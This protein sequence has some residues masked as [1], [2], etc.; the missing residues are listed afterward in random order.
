MLFRHNNLIRRARIIQEIR[1]FFVSQGF[2]EVETPLRIPANAPEEYIDPIC[3]ANWF[4]QTSPEI[5]MKR[6]LCQ[7]HEK[8]FQISHCWRRGERGRHHV[9][10]FTMLEWYRANN[11]YLD[12]MK[13][14]ENLLRWLA[15]ECCQQ[16][17][18]VYQ[19]KNI[20]LTHTA[21]RLTVKEMFQKF[22]ALTMEE[23][24]VGDTFDEI[25]V[26]QIEPALPLDIPVILMDYPVEM[27]ALA[28][29]KPS[30]STI[31]ERFEFYLGGLEL[32]NGF[33]ELNDPFE[34]RK[35]FLLANSKRLATGSAPLPLPEPF[36][37][38]L[39][40]LPPSAGIALGVDRLIMLLV[41]A[42]RIDEVLAF[43]PEDL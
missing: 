17:N 23:A 25:M 27:A 31:A 2:L 14:C 5:C 8:I 41:D 10:E 33:S 20:Y 40:A 38:E 37:T 32:A 28:R 21:K 13:D 39:A 24:I 35:R 34:Q 3:S 22:S 30:D 15:V 7:G 19:G 4:M 42:N 1:H 9:P 18:I 43:S 6:L 11:S 36:L 29:V 16:E 12:L 26:T